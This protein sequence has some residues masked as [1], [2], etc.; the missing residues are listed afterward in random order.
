[1]Q[2]SKTKGLV[3]AVLITGF[4]V[5]M[6][7]SMAGA[8][9]EATVF[10]EA[11]KQT[12]HLEKQLTAHVINGQERTSIELMLNG[13]SAYAYKAEL[14]H[15]SEIKVQQVDGETYATVVYRYIGSSNAV[16]FEVLH[17]HNGNLQSIYQS[18]T[19]ERAQLEW[20]DGRMTLTYPSYETDDVMTDPSKLVTQSFILTAGSVKAEEKQVEVIEEKQSKSNLLAS[21]K[22]PSAAEMNKILTEE[23][24]KAGIAP[25]ILKAIAYQESGWQQYWT[26]VPTSIKKCKKSDKTLP[27][28]GTNVKLG[29][30]CIGIGVMQVSNHMYM[31]EGAEKEAY[32]DRLKND[33]RFNIQEG[34]AILKDKWNY[35]RSGL[36]PTVNNN[37]PMVIENWYFAILAYNG[38]LQRNNPI[39]NAYAAYQEKVLERIADYSLLDLNPFPTHKLNPYADGSLMRFDNKNVTIDGPVHY[40]S[41]S[42]K[43]GDTAYVTVNGLNVR[44]TAGGSVIGKLNKGT[45]VTVTGK[46]AGTNSFYEHYV[47]VPVQAGNVKGWVA[48][49]YLSPTNDYIDA[50]HLQ[51]DTRYETGVSIA[52]HGWHME[53]PDTVVIGRG[54]LPIDALTGSVLA[55]KTGGPLLLTQINKLTPSVAKE[56]KRLNPTTVY[57]LGGNKTA[58]ST[59]VENEIKKSF[60]HVKRI[61]GDTRYE[62]ASQIAEE[63]IGNGSAP[64]IFVTT[65]D[66]KSSDALA[67]APYAGSKNI[68][69]LLTGA[70]KLNKNVSNFISKHGVKKATIIGGDKVITPT[71]EKELNK[72][73]GASNVKRISGTDRFATSIAIADTYYVNKTLTPGKFFI[74]QGLE[75]ADALAA[76]PF[77]AKLNAPIILTL[78]HKIPTDINTWLKNRVKAKQNLYFL[79]GEKAIQTKVR[80]QFLQIIR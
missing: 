25:E 58:I 40:S 22:N 61:E 24:L 77:A 8:E 69:I 49:S 45:K 4:L 11:G 6:I 53:R 52:N 23:A 78:P 10:F 72:L 14:V 28:D 5:F 51:G 43:S 46:Y 29:Y 41:Q 59:T 44:G 19:F 63:V 32:I 68:P 20:E 70:T 36:I 3:Y 47:W 33:L 38:L 71:V 9:D 67:I 27:Y 39:D 42:L 48:S 60:K 21:G 64:E 15:T 7:P 57:I 79:G 80:N 16:M 13:N 66:D 55:A 56:L 35:H 54:D 1:M 65:G 31:K 62:T 75:T 34:I 50:F 26:S 73:L 37:D 12:V 17:V 30:D 2:H 76:A 74:A 18:D